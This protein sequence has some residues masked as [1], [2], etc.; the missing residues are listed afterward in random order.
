M[1]VFA[2]NGTA[3]T[4]DYRA[5]DV[6]YVPFA[7]GHYIQNTGT[8]SVWFLEVF[9]SGRFVDISLN[10]WLALTPPGLIAETLCVGPEV[11]G[12]L[13]KNKW[14]VVEY[15]GYSYYPRGQRPGRNLESRKKR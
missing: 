1:T 3:R 8:E 10:Q 15:P 14:P 13:R 5:G 12:A 4:F 9:K 6:G 2:P 11:M 7:Y